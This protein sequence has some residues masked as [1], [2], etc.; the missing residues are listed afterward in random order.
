[1]LLA[2]DT[3]THTSSIALFDERGVLGEVT[4]QSHENH[5]RSLMPEIV[6]L[7]ELVGTNT[8]ELRAIGVATG[9]GS[10]TGLRIGLS[11]AK[12]LAFSLNAALVGVP[13]L[14]I[15]ASA[16]ADQMLPTC[17]ILHV[18]RGRYGAAIYE[19]HNGIAQRVTDYMF[20]TAET[21]VTL[22]QIDFAKF[23]SILVTGEMDATVRDAFQKIAG[24]RVI[25]TNDGMNVR[26]AGLLAALAWRR[27][28][29][30]DTDDL[31]TLAPYYIP[32]ASLA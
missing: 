6:R 14:D 13:T 11:A 21:L 9:P 26:R 19:N 20:G 18:G 29:N 23:S 31:Q 8:G 15:T 17:A 16:F 30:E 12:G 28:R 3:S 25:L 32:T 22:L 10:F 2:L 27:W 1:M 7:M 5:T 4:W 24:D